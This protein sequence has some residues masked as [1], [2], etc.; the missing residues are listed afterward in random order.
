[1]SR[2]AF[3]GDTLKHRKQREG[4]DEKFFFEQGWFFSELQ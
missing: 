3:I 2:K 4:A 1:M